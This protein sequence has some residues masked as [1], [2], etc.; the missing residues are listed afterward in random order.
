MA[1][2]PQ[3]ELE[4]NKAQLELKKKK[5]DIESYIK[6]GERTSENKKI[7]QSAIINQT[8]KTTSPSIP[9]YALGEID[10]ED[11][12]ENNDT[13]YDSELEEN[14]FSPSLKDINCAT[15]SNNNQ[16]VNSEDW[17]EFRERTIYDNFIY[18]KVI[19]SIILTMSYIFQDIEKEI[20]RLRIESKKNLSAIEFVWQNILTSKHITDEDTKNAINLYLQKWDELNNDAI[21][22][23]LENSHYK[24]AINGLQSLMELLKAESNEDNNLN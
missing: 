9:L 4:R 7:M 21:N 12:Y 8:L 16:M 5:A 22:S 2:L 24:E 6:E 15:N 11:E 19:S 17:E 3:K 13:E 18:S 1:K 20:M 10:T 23:L 14:D